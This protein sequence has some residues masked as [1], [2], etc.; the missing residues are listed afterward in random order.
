MLNII[1]LLLSLVRNEDN[2][3]F[4]VAKTHSIGL[5]VG[6][7]MTGLLLSTNSH[8]GLSIDCHTEMEV[9]TGTSNFCLMSPLYIALEKSSHDG[10]TGTHFVK[11]AYY[12]IY[13]VLILIT[14]FLM[15]IPQWYWFN[16]LHQ[17]FHNLVKSEITYILYKYL[18]I[19]DAF[20]IPFLSRCSSLLLKS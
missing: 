13:P 7:L 2:S 20:L 1:N 8:F 11:V 19:Y 10:Y 17:E 9:P 3:S 6:L 4:M 18:Y 14:A 15:I 16:N 12:K 5:G